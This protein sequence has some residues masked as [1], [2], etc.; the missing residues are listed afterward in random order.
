M[1][2]RDEHETVLTFLFDATLIAKSKLVL[3]TRWISISKALKNAAKVSD[4]RNVSKMKD[5]LIRAVKHSVMNF[6]SVV[7]SILK[8]DHIVNVFNYSFQSAVAFCL[9]RS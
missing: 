8:S 2:T 6:C 4:H 5:L 7:L 1:K 3:G 9:E